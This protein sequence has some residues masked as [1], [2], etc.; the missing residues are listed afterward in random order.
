[1]A[2]GARERG[3]AEGA[4]RLVRHWH[5][6]AEVRAVAGGAFDLDTSA[7]AS[8]ALPHG[9]QPQGASECSV[10]GEAA[11]VIDDVKHER[12]VVA[13]KLHIDVAGARVFDD[14]VHG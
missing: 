2:A 9:A 14:V 4:G 3:A 8:G 12:A 7:D 5:R 13:R 6:G 11:A 10:R 1:R